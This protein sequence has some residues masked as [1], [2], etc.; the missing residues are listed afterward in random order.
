MKLYQYKIELDAKN[1]KVK[2]GLILQCNDNF[3]D[4][5][6]LPGFSR[7]TFE[8]A[9]RETLAWIEKKTP[10]TLPSVRFGIA[11]AQRPLHSL[12][13]PLCALGPREGFS[14]LKLKLGHL[15]I[16][17][18]IAYVKEYVGRY[19]L[20]LDCNRAWS[21]EEALEFCSHF[22][23]EDFAYLEEPVKT[24]PELI[25]FS[26]KTGFPIAL[27]ESIQ[28]N[29]KALPSL[30]AIVVK[31]TVVGGI[32]T[33]P[34]PLTLVLSSAYESGLGL[35]H[36]ASLSQSSIPLGLDTYRSLKNDFLINPIECANG[37]FSWKATSPPIDV[38]RL[39]AL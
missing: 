17:E 19:R 21:L 34:A 15:S 31:P 26:Q 24:F 33:I 36:I 12:H 35:L 22:K 13:L 7:E 3:G 27:D 28:N 18:A 2:E 9:K 16:S 20:R 38:S 32:P 30:K 37:F 10:P 14:T 23:K 6:P 1:W 11:C 8:E 29:W 25:Q 4:I 39:C 5:S